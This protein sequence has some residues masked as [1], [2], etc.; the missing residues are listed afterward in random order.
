MQDLYKVVGVSR[1]GF[2]DNEVRG[3]EHRLIAD[4][5]LDWV[6]NLRIDHPRMGAR[7]VYVK[8][9]KTPE[10]E[11][12][13]QKIG[14]D[15]LEMIL[16]NNNLRIRTVKSF[17]KTTIR[18]AFIFKNLLQDGIKTFV[19]TAINQ[20]WVSDLT[21]YI[22]VQNGRVVHYYITL[23]M[24][25]FS[26]EGIGFAVSQTMITEDTTLVALNRAFKYRN[27]QSKEK[28]PNL[29]FHSDG[30]G[31]FSDKEFLRLLAQHEIKSSMGK[32]AYENPNAER[33]NGILKNEYLLP[34]E[35]NSLP[36]L[37]L[38]TPIAIKFY[39]TQRPHKSLNYAT[40]LEFMKAHSF[41]TL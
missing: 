28:L 36:Q 25:L 2:F 23:I 16:L 8:L 1:Q 13:L 24:D 32:Q 22:V 19:P 40:P 33:F 30:G 15:K 14:R 10:Y 11:N 4:Q 12:Y 38:R 39:N 5:I 26:R 9:K 21:Y 41:V 17:I 27:I 6:K 7:K 37:V 20:V 18:G 29:I 31:Q 3:V 34:W 35:V